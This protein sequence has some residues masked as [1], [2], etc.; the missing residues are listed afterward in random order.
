MSGIRVVGAGW[1]RVSATARV[2]SIISV[3]EHV[4]MALKYGVPRLRGE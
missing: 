2:V 4:V 1:E 3:C